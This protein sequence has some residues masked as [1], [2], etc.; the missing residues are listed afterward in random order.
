MISPVTITSESCSA[1]WIGLSQ[2]HAGHSGLAGQWA[3][4]GDRSGPVG[5][6]PSKNPGRREDCQQKP[7]ENSRR[8]ED[9]QQWLD[10]DMG[11]S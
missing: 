5:E 1:A 9:G 10:H 8:M 4:A 3:V 6:T 7:S 11:V 2:L